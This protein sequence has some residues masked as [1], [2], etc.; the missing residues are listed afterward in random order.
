MEEKDSGV[1]LKK[2][3]DSVSEISSISGFRCVVRKQCRDLSRR[4]KLLMPLLEEFLEIRD[5]ISEETLNGL[6]LLK[7]AL[8]SAVE[9]LKMCNRGSSV[10]LVSYL[11][12]LCFFFCCS[13]IIA[14]YN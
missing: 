11:F 7:G 5:Q 13:I 12:Y 1:V 2:L 6:I 14:E 3:V 9:L 4:V 8:E 10:L